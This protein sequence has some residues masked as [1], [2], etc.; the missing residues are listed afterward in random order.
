[1]ALVSKIQY[2]YKPILIWKKPLHITSQ[3][4]SDI[5][6]EICD[7]CESV[8]DQEII[9]L[10]AENRKLKKL[11]EFLRSEI[12]SLEFKTALSEK[13]V[14]LKNIV[15]ELTSTPEGKTAWQEA[16]DKRA[17]EWKKYM[18]LGKISRIKYFRLLKGMDQKTLAKKLGTAQPNISRIEK[19]GYN[20]PVNTLKKLAKIFDVKMED[21]I[22]D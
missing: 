6:D 22:G 19:P 10:K 11:V 20:V 14:P 17:E 12:R 8:K 21:L 9:K 3:I 4:S 16:W 1:M 18:E 5:L 13:V 7:T 15:E 2:P